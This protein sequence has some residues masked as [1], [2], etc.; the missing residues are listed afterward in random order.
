V[1]PRGPCHPLPCWDSVILYYSFWP[2]GAADAPSVQARGQLPPQS[3]REPGRGRRDAAPWPVRD[4]SAG[5]GTPALHS[6]SGLHQVDACLCRAG[7]S[8]FS[9]TWAAEERVQTIVLQFGDGCTRVCL[10]TATSAKSRRPG[11]GRAV[12]YPPER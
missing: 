4:P 8:R 6:A 3:H 5:Q 10:A 1:T 11:T 9:F 7:G 12:V 2:I